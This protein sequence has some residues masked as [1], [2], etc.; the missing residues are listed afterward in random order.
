MREHPDA[1]IFIYITASSRD[2]ALKIGR[3]LVV[4]RL[5][6][7]ANVLPG[8]R[9]IYR[10]QGKV[11]E[12]EECVLVAKTRAG[13]MDRLVGRVRALHSYTCPA[14]VALPILAGNPDYLAW[15]AAETKEPT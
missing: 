2:E 4:E 3:V 1:P 5:V 6:A 8:A 15:I 11:K 14:I 12:A 9:S 13:L 7:S 10:W